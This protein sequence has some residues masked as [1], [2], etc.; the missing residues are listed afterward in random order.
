MALSSDAL[1]TASGGTT[2]RARTRERRAPGPAAERGIT[3]EVVDGPMDGTVLSGEIERIRIGRLPHNDLELHSDRS[4]SGEHASLARTAD[5]RLWRLEDVRSTNGTWIEDSRLAGAQDL[6]LDTVFMV[7]HSVVRLSA[8]TG[9]TSFAPS[10][11][12][13]REETARLAALFAPET[14]EG[15][16]AAVGLATAEQRPFIADRHFFLGLAVMNPEAPI[17]ARG[18]GPVTGQFLSEVLRR[19]DYWTGPRAWID[20]R[21]RGSTMDIPALFEDDLLVTPRLLRL[22]LKAEEEARQAGAA[23]IRPADVFRAFLTGPENRPR[24]LLLR[25]GIATET[26]LALLAAAGPA[27]RPPEQKTSFIDPALAAASA[28]SVMAAAPQAPPPAPPVLLSSGDPALD[29]RA[30]ETAR[31]LYGVA[32]LYHLAAAGDRTG[33]LKQI[34]VEEIAQVPADSRP[35]LLGQVQRLF[36]VAAPNPA[37]RE[38][39]DRKRDET[40]GAARAAAAGLPWGALL[41]NPSEEALASLSPADR[42]AVELYTDLLGF[43]GAMERFIASIVQDLRAP[44]LG[45]ESLQLPGY[46][47]TLKGFA[48]ELAEGKAPRRAALQ[49]YLT[50]VETWMIAVLAAYHEGPDLWFKEFWSRTSPAAIES[51]LAEENRKK[52]FGLRPDFWARYKE[53]V[54]TVSLD[55]VSDEIR[56]VVSKRA[57][58]QFHQFFERRKPS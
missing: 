16:G 28:A 49:E 13:I 8:G 47:I 45:T 12:T 53:R 17:L 31:R 14:A 33:A 6:P 57:D 11:Q 4:V 7:A 51:P 50:A 36:P 41:V 20:R 52:G 38:R 34:L 15:Y 32:S 5:G 35:R 39:T 26:L 30:Q 58:E 10:A 24:E 1:P 40:E 46:R 42:P 22:L 54:R 19:N 55:L 9:D 27:E 21:L 29:A 43:A 18:R 23:T 2:V 56:R 48:K 3:L 44:G 25:A 37:P